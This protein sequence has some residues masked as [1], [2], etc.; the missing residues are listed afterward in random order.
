[1]EREKYNP[2]PIDEVELLIFLLDGSGSMN[3]R[4]NYD[5]NGNRYGK[6]KVDYQT[7]LVEG[8]IDRLKNSSVRGRF[9]CVIIYFA[10]K[11]YFD[12]KLQSKYT[13]LDNIK[14]ENA[15]QKAKAGRTAIVKA[16]KSA[17]KIIDTFIQDKSLPKEKFASIFLFTDGGESENTSGRKA[18]EE[19]TEQIKS[20]K[21][22]PSLA[23]ISF[24]PKAHES[25]LEKISSDLRPNQLRALN[26]AG[27]LRHLTNINKAFIQGHEN[28]VITD[29]K[30]EILRTFVYVMSSTV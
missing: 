16:L 2:P 8:L 3:W 13:T 4:S 30:I 15:V 27:I 10:T 7:E 29:E 28:G 5:S 6:K 20:G 24:G 23:T 1:M 17:E 22:L 26:N 9:R 21:I 12:D 11:I 25:L 14:V 19:I 18:V